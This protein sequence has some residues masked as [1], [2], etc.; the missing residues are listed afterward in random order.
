MERD[1]LFMYWKFV[2]PKA[3]NRANAV[4]FKIAMIFFTGEK[5]FLKYAWKNQ[6]TRIVKA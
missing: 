2:S 6:D 5:K 3:F 4:S 1:S